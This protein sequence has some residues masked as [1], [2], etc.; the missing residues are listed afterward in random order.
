[1]RRASID[2]PDD[3]QDPDRAGAVDG[4]HLVPPPS[5]GPPTG[6]RAAGDDPPRAARRHVPVTFAW[7]LN[8][9]FAITLRP[10]AAP[11]DLADLLRLIPA[12]VVFT[13]AFGDLEVVLA[14]R[15]EPGPPPPPA[16]SPPSDPPPAPMPPV[17]ASRPARRPAGRRG[18]PAPRSPES[19]GPWEVPAGP[20]RDPAGAAVRPTAAPAGD[21]RR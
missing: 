4:D 12:G 16:A 7:S 14:F 17:P 3:S 19:P 13:E 10:G 1:M 5:G 21:E 15:G 9:G 2:P 11:A 8:E 6:G 18:R 20:G